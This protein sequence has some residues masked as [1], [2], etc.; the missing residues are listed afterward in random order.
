ME[1]CHYGGEIEGSYMS[2]YIIF[3]SLWADHLIKVVKLACLKD[4]TS[5][6]G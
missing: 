1:I 5:C 6:A 4:P 2:Y 3:S